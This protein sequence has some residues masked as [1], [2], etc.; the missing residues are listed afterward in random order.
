MRIPTVQ[1]CCCFLDLKIGV[2]A[3][4]GLTA[5]MSIWA[6]I[7]GIQDASVWCIL[8]GGKLN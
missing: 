5:L 8:P 6:L 7:K 3:I 1:K 2:L 4:S